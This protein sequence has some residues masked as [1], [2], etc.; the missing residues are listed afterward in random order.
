MAAPS[1][2][3]SSSDDQVD[4]VADKLDSLSVVGSGDDTHVHKRQL[5]PEYDVWNTCKVEDCDVKTRYRWCQEHYRAHIAEGQE[6]A[7]NDCSRMTRSRY[8][9]ACRREY[10][11]RLRLCKNRNCKEL[12][13]YMF[14]R[15]CYMELNE[16]ANDGCK[17]RSKYVQCSVCYHAENN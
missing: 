5:A 8:C 6:C 14:C 16:C 4:A 15:P 13:Q 2:N 3:H 11:N 17:R 12:T 7:T 10:R 9:F 1:S